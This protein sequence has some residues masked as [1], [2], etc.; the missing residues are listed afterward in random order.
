[1]LAYLLVEII[2]FLKRCSKGRQDNDVTILHTFE[3]FVSLAD[4]FNELYLHVMKLVVDLR[5]VDE[6]V[7][8]VNLLVGEVVDG[9]ISQ[10]DTSFDAPTKAEILCGTAAKMRDQSTVLGP[11]RAA[12]ANRGHPCRALLYNDVPWPSTP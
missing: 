10:R 11:T 8:N 7:G 12:P 1:M 4:L 3:I 5:V 9:F 2:H 6:F